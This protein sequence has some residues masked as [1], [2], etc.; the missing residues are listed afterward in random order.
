M[1][2]NIPLQITGKEDSYDFPRSW[3][4]PVLREN[5][6]NANL[7][8]F[9]TYFLPMA[10]ACQNRAEQADKEGDKIGNKSYEMLVSQIWALL[11]GFCNNP[12]DLKESFDDIVKHMGK[13]LQDR[14]DLRMYILASLRQLILKNAGND[15]NKAVLSKWAKKFLDTM[16]NLYIKRP[17]G[18]EESGQRLSIMETI[19]LFL[20]LVEPPLLGVHFDRLFSTISEQTNDKIDEFTREACHDLLRVMLKYQDHNRVEQVYRLAANAFTNK[21]YKKQKKAYKLLE[22][23]CA[24]ESESCQQFLQTNLEDIQKTLLNSLSKAS[25]PSQA[26][27]IKCLTNIVRN[28]VQGGANQEQFLYKIV[29]EAILCVRAAN[30]KARSGSYTLLVVIG[31][32]LQK[33]RSQDEIDTVIKDSVLD[34]L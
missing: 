1:L 3:L 27:R 16:C 19:K 5:I 31:E 10:M 26:S 23:I 22:E 8:F 29:P 28:L 9:K 2:S 7:S 24:S 6:Q 11:P 25:P 17:S 20:Q 21:D 4:L 33:W 12:K 14:K 13:N 32:T 18:A 34:L 30:E 15:E